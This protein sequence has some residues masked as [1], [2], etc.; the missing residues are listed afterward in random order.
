[1]KYTVEVTI[2][3]GVD[4]AG[5]LPALLL[6][7]GFEA[8]EEIEGGIKAYLAEEDWSQTTAAEL[9]ALLR[10]LGVNAKAVVQKIEERDWNEIWESSLEPIAVGRFCII[11]VHAM[12]G[13]HDGGERIP[14]YI[15][16]QMSFG[17]GYHATTRLMLQLM[18]EKI[19]EGDRVLD[20]GTGTGVLAIAAIK[21]GAGSAFGFDIDHWA[22][23]NAPENVR[24][25]AVEDRVQIAVG[26]IEMAPEEPYD[27]ILANIN[28][29]VLIAL[30][31][32]FEARLSEGGSLILSGVLSKDT[33]IL[34]Q[35]MEACG[36]GPSTTRTEGE[37]M[38]G[39]C[40]RRAN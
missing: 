35:A 3:C 5:I 16:P 2:S 13:S 32:D 33:D 18:Q 4:Q 36:L 26:G 8:F 22:G 21:L 25:N 31:P 12:S 11:P 27:V 1:M 19:G 38:A 37:W 30:M 6:D 23:D 17:T 29:N 14:L 28:L 9:E 10:T 7:V 24:R 34:V 39:I 20:A 40:N 15:Q